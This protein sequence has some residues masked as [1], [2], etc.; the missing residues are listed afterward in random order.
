MTPD[1][2][3]ATSPPD[4]IV[5][6]TTFAFAVKIAG[7][8]FTAGL[9]LFLVR[10]LGPEDYGVFSLAVG[11]ASLAVMIADFGVSASAARFV[12]EHRENAG[13]VGRVLVDSLKLK[14]IASGF[15]STVIFALSST[16]ANAYDT[17]AMTWPLRLMCVAVFAQSLILLFTAA[18][19]ALW[20]VALSLRVVITES[21]VETGAS[22]LLVLAGGGATAAAAGRAIG[23]GVAVIVAIPLLLRLIGR[24]PWRA[25]GPDRGSWRQIAGYAAAVGVI[26]GALTVFSRIDVLLIG[27]YLGAASVGRFEAPL[28]LMSFLQNA[29]SAIAGGVAPRI[30]RVEGSEPNVAAFALG[31]RVVIVAQG[32]VLAP[33]VVWATPLVDLALGSGYAE[34]ASVLRGLAPFALLAGVAPLLGRGVNYLGEARRRVPAAIAAVV[35]NLVIDLI[36][37]PRIGIVGGAIG[38]DVAYAVYVAVHLQICRD[39]IG[40]RLT[41]TMV[42]LGRTLL[43]ATAM[44]GLLY[45][46]GTEGLSISAWLIGAVGGTLVYVAVLLATREV[47]IA[48]LRSLRR[49]IAARLPS[50]G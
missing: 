15:V 10:R 2:G 36:L 26:D 42:T 48:E 37:I 49:E 28:S 40:M 25:P 45:A 31:L 23:M 8:L 20:R 29:G 30:A 21:A 1:A 38:T 13:R 24:H 14:L 47:T 35:I 3:P 44:A 27:A 32:I 22:V 4:S 16:I 50:R 46:L 18:F 5:R 43:A 19:E 11:V 33:I 34:S 6:N 17:P 7:A 12:A 39:F 9:T 41:P